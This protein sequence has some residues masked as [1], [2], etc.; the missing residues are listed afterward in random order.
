MRISDSG[1]GL[2]DAWSDEQNC[3]VTEIPEFEIATTLL[4]SFK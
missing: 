3:R 1:L 4:H 2:G